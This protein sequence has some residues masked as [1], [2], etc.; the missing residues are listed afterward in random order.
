VV[1]TFILIFSSCAPDR[2]EKEFLPYVI[3]SGE[4][5]H[6]ITEEDAKTLCQ[7]AFC[8]KNQIYTSQFG[9]KRHSEPVIAPQPI[10]EPV[11]PF[12]ESPVQPPEVLDYS[13]SV[14]NLNE[15]WSLTEGSREVLVAVIDSGVDQTHPDLVANIDLING[16]DFYHDRV[17]AQDDNGHGTHVS[18]IIAAV[19]NSIGTRGVAP[20][21]RILPL[22]FLGPTG[23]GDTADAV[24]AIDYAVLKGAKVISNSWGGA[25]YSELLNQAIQRAI[26]AGIHFVAAAGNDARDNDAI[27]TYPANYPNVISVGS[28]DQLDNKSSFSNVGLRSVM[29]FAPGSDIY[30]AYP[31]GSYRFMSGTSMATPQVAGAIAL[32]LSLKSSLSVSALR[33]DLCDSTVKRLTQFSVCGRMDVGRFIRQVS[34]R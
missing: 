15:A 18:G 29:I 7:D 23:S 4:G 9:R 11:Q 30:S 5:I 3:Q 27:N 12:P 14:L 21:V 25:G 34:T 10:L 28:S 1:F 32:A 33:S 22:K 17:G 8:E 19:K 26:S 13:R 16:Y 2:G 31:G 20:K 24:R 6:A